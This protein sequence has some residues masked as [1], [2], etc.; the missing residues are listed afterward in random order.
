MNEGKFRENAQKNLALYRK[1]RSRN[2]DEVL[3]QPQ[4]IDILKAAAKQD[5]FAHSYL[6]VGQ[7]G[8]GKTSVARILAHLIN[9]T[10]YDAEDFDIIEIDAASHGSVDDARELRERA[11]L[12]PLKSRNKVYIIDEVHMLSRQAF[13]ALLKLIEEPPAHL[14]FILA[15]TEFAKVPATI[16][17]RVQR[18][19]FRPV[20][21]EIV[22]EHLREISDREQIQID[23]EALLLIA[24]RGEGSFRDSITL[25][26]QIKNS[27]AKITRE[28]VEEIL[29]LANGESISRIVEFV[30]TESIA[31]LARELNKLFASGNSASELA[32]QLIDEFAKLAIARPEFYEL[33]EKLLDVAKSSNPQIKLVSVLANFAKMRN[34]DD[35][36]RK[37]VSELV[38][39]PTSKTIATSAE[40]SRKTEKIATTVIEK[41]Q[42]PDKKSKKS[43]EI[44]EVNKREKNSN[45]INKN[46]NLVAKISRKNKMKSDEF[47]WAKCLE[48]FAN[49][50]EPAAFALAKGAEFRYEDSELMLFFAKKFQ[51]GKANTKNFREILERAIRESHDGATPTKII[52]SDESVPEDS[53]AAK[54]LDILGGEV[55]SI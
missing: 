22:A 14:Y 12:A 26:D 35:I 2:L 23:D 1:Y 46:E 41:K 36:S 20:A 42:I 9:A 38:K 29:G 40:I 8:T 27:P 30:D 33:I 28:V 37:S 24:N 15:T 45:K 4:V 18:F 3:G 31:E 7:R 52:I 10:D 48:T 43:D 6:L 25:L 5:I 53:N 44:T 49:L 47:D 19:T 16:L 51:R 11:N 54:V 39:K 34:S 32:K 17:S 50:N 13:D 55:I 21:A